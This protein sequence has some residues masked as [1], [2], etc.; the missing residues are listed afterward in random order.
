MAEF[1]RAQKRIEE[2]RRIL[3]DIV[4][5]GK[6]TEEEIKTLEAIE[7]GAIFKGFPSAMVQGGSLKFGDEATGQIRGRF[8][9]IPTDI[10]TDIERA[11]Y[12]TYSQEHPIRAFAG[13]TLGMLPL[14]VAT[15]G[16][17]LLGSPTLTAATTGG[18]YGLGYDEG[19]LVD[20][21]DT[22]AVGAG[23]GVV[24]RYA[25]PMVGGAIKKGYTTF[26]ADPIKRGVKD[27]RKAVTEAIESG[28]TTL[29]EAIQIIQKNTGKIYS[30]A[31]LNSSTRGLLDTANILPHFAST[32]TIL[33]FLR[34]RDSGRLARIKDDVYEAFGNN[35][36]YFSTLTAIKKARGKA[37]ELN[38]DKANKISLSVDKTLINIINK[39]PK[40]LQ[41]RI[42]T[43]IQALAK[44]EGRVLPDIKIVNNRLVDA[45]GNKIVNVQTEYL[46]YLQRALRAAGKPNNVVDEGLQQELKF[47]IRN[48]HK[49]LIDFMSKNNN[50]YKIAINKY[51][52]DSAIMD[53][54]DLGYNILK[55]NPDEL[56]AI[57]RNMTTS[58]RQGFRNGTMNAI[59]ES[60]ESKGGKN[61][62]YAQQL[63]KSEKMIKLLRLSFGDFTKRGTVK[64]NKFMENLQK[65]I[66]TFETSAT[67]RG[68]SATAFRQQ[69]VKGALSE[70][71]DTLNITRAGDIF[72]SLANALFKQPN[73]DK[74]YINS[75]AGELARILTTTGAN[76]KVLDSISKDLNAGMGIRPAIAKNYPKAT[77]AITNFLNNPTFKGAGVG[78]QVT[79]Y[80]EETFF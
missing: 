43:D 36:R 24:A 35:G 73:A 51:A 78:G 50:Q 26:L 47:G 44:M 28:A 65:E 33:D 29:N 27:A 30:L 63:I 39:I 80:A 41:E 74:K 13:E 71:G 31:D 7:S 1:S 4:K 56:T 58:E 12:D 18:L 70:A 79:P 34:N 25:L 77:D 38:Y 23:T 17:S 42:H 32:K 45:N 61:P 40:A 19:D 52:G 68:N 57:V 48:V 76:K 20:R 66:N 75:Y 11:Q 69:A 53:A 67:V 16:R 2:E 37:A 22:G 64:F 49:E 15:R 9:G 3:Q 55:Q 59:I 5:T 46:H 8:S 54:M 62:D 60:L 72:T 21:L 6:A 14:A 10:A